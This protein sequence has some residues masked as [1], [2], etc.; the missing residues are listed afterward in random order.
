M[1][2]HARE[3]MVGSPANCVMLRSVHA[4]RR[5]T[6]CGSRLRR[7]GCNSNAHYS[8]WSNRHLRCG[9][10]P[11]ARWY[12]T[13]IGMSSLNSIPPIHHIHLGRWKGKGERTRSMSECCPWLD[14][15]ELKGRPWPSMLNDGFTDRSV[16][17]GHRGEPRAKELFDVVFIDFWR[18]AV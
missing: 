2:Q 6:W 12:D 8:R 15:H 11:H 9:P 10:H 1:R 7:C 5:G 13:T 14:G 17:H 4:R 3:M 18:G 16:T